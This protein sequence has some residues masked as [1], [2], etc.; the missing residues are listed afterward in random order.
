[1]ARPG[2]IDH[3]PEAENG[4]HG[5]R[6]N[7][8]QPG[9]TGNGTCAVRLGTQPN[10][11]ISGLSLLGNA[12]SMDLPAIFT[13]FVVPGVLLTGSVMFLITDISIGRATIISVAR[14][15]IT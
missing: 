5:R 12:Q 13:E 14:T 10:D 6:H 7:R 2:L 1:M 4:D 15:A 11:P 9:D 8:H 3:P